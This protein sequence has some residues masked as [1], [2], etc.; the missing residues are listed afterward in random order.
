MRSNICPEVPSRRSGDDGSTS[1][2]IMRAVAAAPWDLDC[3]GKGKEGGPALRA[4]MFILERSI[5]DLMCS[6]RLYKKLDFNFTL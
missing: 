6:L 4:S 1:E 5:F 2:L 3:E